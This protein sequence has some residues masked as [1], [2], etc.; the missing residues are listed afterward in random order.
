MIK[1]RLLIASGIFLLFLVCI[2]LVFSF[3][4]SAL[5]STPSYSTRSNI[6]GT[7]T[8]QY[9]FNS[10]GSTFGAPALDFA[11]EKSAPLIAPQ[12]ND[13][14][15]DSTDRK[16]IK[17]GTLNIVVKDV[18]DSVKKISNQ[19]TNI[20]GYVSTT[21]FNNSG[22]KSSISG[23]VR[24]RIPV[25]RV[26][27]FVD[28]VKSVA[29]EVKSENIN[30]RDVTSEYIDLEA[31]IKNLEVTESK[32]QEFMEK[33]VNVSEV[34]QVQREL[35][36]VRQQIEQLRGQLKYLEGNAEYSDITV[37]IALDAAELPVPPEDKWKPGV[38]FKIALNNVITLAKNLSYV[39][40]YLGVF[41]II[42]IPIGFGLW[43]LYKFLR[44]KIS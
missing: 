10:T 23:Y 15:T 12:P 19:S 21:N 30:S 35:T 29:S 27:E 8:A 17:N 44:R 41:S 33:A 40:I 1:K 25:D 39:A 9:D 28:F 34:L 4:G 13:T 32:Y 38:V 18:E 14:P 26:P 22:N 3:V 2:M 16:I 24:V 36:T 6:T 7:S 37:N 43:R 11:Q 20:G 31:R 5:R 42:W